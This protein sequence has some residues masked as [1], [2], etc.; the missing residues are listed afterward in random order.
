MSFFFGPLAGALCA[1][2]V[3]YGF[4]NLIQ[5]R[6]EQHRKDLHHL[7]VRLLETPSIVIPPPPAAARVEHHP[8]RSLVHSRWNQEI[9]SLFTWFRESDQVVDDW[10]KKLSGQKSPGRE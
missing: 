9:E 1:G 4:S 6:T 8:F 5:T 10:R 7:S 3:Y 2:G